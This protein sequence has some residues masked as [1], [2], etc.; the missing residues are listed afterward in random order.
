MESGETAQIVSLNF[1]LVREASQVFVVSSLI[2]QINCF[3]FVLRNKNNLPFKISLIL[4]NMLLILHL[5]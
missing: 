2:F 5:Y 1:R 4:S 3:G